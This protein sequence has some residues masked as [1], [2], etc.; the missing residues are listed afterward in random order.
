MDAK[1]TEYFEKQKPA[2]KQICLELRSILFS[3]FPTLKEEMKWGVP[4]YNDGEFYIVC[5]KDHVNLGFSSINLSKDEISLFDGGGKTTRNLQI[6]SAKEI[7]RE[8]IVKLLKLV[9]SKN[10]SKT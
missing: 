4:A 8:K 6:S 9:H 10:D 3:E 5:L 1:V 2:F 7:E